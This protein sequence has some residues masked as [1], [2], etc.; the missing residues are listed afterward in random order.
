MRTTVVGRESLPDETSE[1]Y[2][3]LDHS[4]KIN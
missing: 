1:G 3:I 2:N 4:Q